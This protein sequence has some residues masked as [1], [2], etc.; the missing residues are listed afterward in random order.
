MALTDS[1]RKGLPP[2]PF[3]YTVDQLSVILSLT[4]NT[5]HQQHLYHEGRDVGIN[6]KW[7]MTARN[8][9]PPDQRPDWRVTETELLRWMKH[10]GFKFYDRGVRTI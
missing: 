10:K 6:H 4:E 2:R 9:A 5:L 8:I 3:L 1:E 7:H